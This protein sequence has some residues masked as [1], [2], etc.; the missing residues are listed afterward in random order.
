MVVVVVVVVVL[1]AGGGVSVIVASVVASGCVAASD[2]DGLLKVVSGRPCSGGGGC[3]G[4]E[5][6]SVLYLTQAVFDFET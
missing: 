6:E 1:V 5:E 4:R 2:G 3:Q